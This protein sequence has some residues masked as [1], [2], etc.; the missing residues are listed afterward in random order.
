M[1]LA[2]LNIAYPKFANDDP[3][4]AGF[5]D[6]LNRINELGF[7]MPGF[8][9]SFTQ[10]CRDEASCPSVSSVPDAGFRVDL[11]GVKGVDSGVE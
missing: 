10:R 1:H 2:E 3:R 7:S 11:G 6:N 4:F 5:I 9:W 8:V